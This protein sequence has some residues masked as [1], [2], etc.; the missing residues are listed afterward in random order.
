[1]FQK[2]P[3]DN[4]ELIVGCIYFSERTNTEQG[5]ESLSYLLY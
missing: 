4:V 5:L 1:L 3:N 2:H